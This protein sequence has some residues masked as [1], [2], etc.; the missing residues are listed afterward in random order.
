MHW[1][2]VRRDDLPDNCPSLDALHAALFEA[3]GSE[4]GF[5]DFPDLTVQWLKDHKLR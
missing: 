1:G 3:A 2:V 5:T 4:G